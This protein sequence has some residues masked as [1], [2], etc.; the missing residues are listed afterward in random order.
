MNSL[1]R[2]FVTR[3]RRDCDLNPGL[4]APESSTL[5]T[6]LPSHPVVPVRGRMRLYQRR[7]FCRL[8]SRSSRRS[9]CCCVRRGYHPHSGLDLKRTVRIRTLFYRKLRVAPPPFTCVKRTLQAYT[10]TLTRSLS[11]FHIVCARELVRHYS[12][13]SQENET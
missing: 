12:D 10:T 8:F 13:K 3:Q 6:R 2:L 4:S 9:P 11:K 7:C 1:R 5:T